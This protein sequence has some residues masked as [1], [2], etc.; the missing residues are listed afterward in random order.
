MTLASVT[1]SWTDV[2]LNTLG[3]GMIVSSCY[4][5]HNASIQVQPANLKLQFL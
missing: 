2:T 3:G 4:P 5:L 1:L